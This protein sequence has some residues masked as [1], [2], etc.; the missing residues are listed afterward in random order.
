ML[1]DRVFFV[2][3]SFL[4]YL[5]FDFCVFLRRL[6]YSPFFKVAGRNLRILDGVTIKYPSD[7]EIGDDVTINQGCIINGRGGL[8][9][10]NDVMM[11]AGTKIATTDHNTDRTDVP[12]RTQGLTLR[13]IE[14]EDDVWFG[15]DAVILGGS[16]IRKG[17]IV[18]AGCVVPGKE[19]PEYSVAAAVPVRVIKSRVDVEDG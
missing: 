10:G 7:I 17:S 11:G 3:Q 4:K 2:I 16:T 15:F 12:M 13:R 8:A 14:I 1:N 6:L 9:I 18:A 19:I 5:P